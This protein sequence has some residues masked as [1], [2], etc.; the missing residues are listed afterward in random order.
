MNDLTDKSAPQAD[1][2]EEHILQV[3]DTGRASQIEDGA[4]LLLRIGQQ[5]R[6][7]REAQGK[8]LSDMVRELKLRKVYLEAMENGDWDVLPDEVYA[9]GFLRQ[10][11][12]HLKL[13]LDDDVNKI[14]NRQYELTRPLTFPDPPVAPSRRWAWIAAAAF[15]ILFLAFNVLNN[16]T[17]DIGPATLPNPVVSPPPESGTPIVG[18]EANT[19]E[20][21]DPDI[22]GTDIPAE[23]PANATST[24]ADESQSN[25][26]AVTPA[27]KEAVQPSG[28]MHSF[29]FE[30]IND[31]VWLQVYLP[32]AS[33]NTMGELRREVLLN[34]GYHF[35]LNEPFN[36]LWLTTGNAGALQIRIDE[37]LVNEAGSLGDIGSVLRN[38]QL[39]V[40]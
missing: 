2:Q 34:P 24:T 12:A 15:L 13:D 1:N 38:Y 35:T 30:A 9:I 4:S 28:T 16:E 10:Y 6:Q 32:D 20:M 37:K 22:T 31:A 3:E 11:A 39:N 40:K 17:E 5:L 8:Q 27:N 7:A 25:M 29:R 21:N 23:L 18:G 14:R 36:S 19:L 33:G 26:D